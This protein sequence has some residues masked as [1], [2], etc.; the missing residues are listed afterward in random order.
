MM[1]VRPVLFVA[2]QDP[3][4]RRILP[5]A[6]IAIDERGEYEFAYVRA[7]ENAQASGF[8]PLVPFPDLRTVYR[9]QTLLPILHNRL[10]QPNRPDYR[11]HLLQL[12]LEPI[13]L[14]PFAI[15]ARSGGRRVT[16]RLELFAPPTLSGQSGLSCYALVRGVRYKSG[17][18]EAIARINAGDRLTVSRDRRIQSMPRRSSC[19]TRRSPSGT[20]Q[21]I[22]RPNW[23]A[24]QRR[25]TWLYGV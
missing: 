1:P 23:R 20:S 15:L 8:L 4:S 22:S 13:E 7:V 17:S 24:R 3:V 19:A 2:W 16:D 25:S 21:I 12:G 10:V 18:E 11:E 6:R 9:S 14:N 5:V